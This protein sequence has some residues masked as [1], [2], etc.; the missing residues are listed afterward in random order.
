M[1]ASSQNPFLTL[2]LVFIASGFTTQLVAQVSTWSPEFYYGLP[3][4]AYS[5]TF[6]EPFD[7]NDRSW[8][9]NPKAAS[10]DIREGDLHLANRNNRGTSLTRFAP[11]SQN[12]DYE[13]E[14]QM[15]FVRGGLD[16]PFGMVF[17]AD[18]KGQR[19]EFLIN[20]NGRCQVRAMTEEGVKA[21]TGWM[22]QA[23][24]GRYVYNVLTLRKIN[25]SW[26][27]FLNRNKVLQM[28][29]EEFFGFEFG[30]A[31]WGDVTA[32]FDYLTIQRIRKMDL[33][34][35]E[36][37]LDAPIITG[38]IV[39]TT[40]NR[41]PVQGYVKDISGISKLLINGQAVIPDA[42]G[43]F[44]ANLELREGKNDVEITAIDFFQ[45]PATKSFSV[46]YSTPSK[47][48]NYLL[49]IGIDRYQYWNPLHNATKDCR[50]I[51]QV[52]SNSYNFDPSYTIMLSNRQATRERILE[53]LE[54]LQS[55][56]SE[57]DNL[58]IYYA[59]HGYYDKRSNRGYWVPV[60]ARLNKISD[61]IRNSTIHDYL[62][63]I[64]THNTLLIADACY[65]GSLFDNARGVVDEHSPSRWAFTSG[66]IEK[67][68]DGQP[69]QNSPF[70]KFLIEYLKRNREPRLRADVLIDA[71]STIVMRNTQQSP[72]GSPLK[73]V[74]DQGGVF[75]FERKR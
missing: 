8:D 10:A 20:A 31:A 63:G 23:L 61:Y 39:N 11:I 67:V 36:I 3:R 32:E 47:G 58:L 38:N 41:Q 15:R 52:L 34:P 2:L 6:E 33:L 18:Q 54:S 75:V 55:R 28:K 49:M 24:F 1:R 74:G 35:P 46:V 62:N 9:L 13:I 30:L 16:R 5:M 73:N 70:A 69:G 27:F 51:K 66:D 19:Y 45:N 4:D 43:H 57:D 26:Y 42:S 68:W 21:Y 25:D 60:D 72:V 12:G 53:T 7:N 59:G 50:D 65:A 40:V 48:K 71:V 64:K 44:S 22:P 37:V 29:A 56:L 17:G 14:M